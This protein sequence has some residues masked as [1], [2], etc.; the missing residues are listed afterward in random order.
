MPKSKLDFKTAVFS[1]SKPVFKEI[2]IPAWGTSIFIRNLSLGAF[3]A[4]E[5]TE[6]EATASGIFERFNQLF[7]DETGNAIF[8]DEDKEDFANKI[9]FN[10]VHSL[11]LQAIDA[12]ASKGSLEADVKN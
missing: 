2:E 10:L 12:L 11:V 6:I 4:M 9:P 7:C 8:S 3:E 1:T 5:K